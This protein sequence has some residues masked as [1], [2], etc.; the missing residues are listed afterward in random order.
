VVVLL[1]AAARW[2]PLPYPPLGLTSINGF[3]FIKLLK[4]L[5]ERAYDLKLNVMLLQSSLSWR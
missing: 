1:L 3:F 2:P 4:E 5:M